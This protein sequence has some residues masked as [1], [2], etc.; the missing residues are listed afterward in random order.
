MTER[1]R[2]RAGSAPAAKHRAPRRGTRVPGFSL[3]TAGLVAAGLLVVVRPAAAP[4]PAYVDAAALSSVDLAA[5]NSRDVGQD[6]ALVVEKR[7]VAPET[8]TITDDTIAKGVSYVK[9]P[10]AAG[11]EE[12][13]YRVMLSRGKEVSRSVVSRVSVK[14]AVDTVIVQGSG[15]PAALGANLDSLA[16]GTTKPDGARRWAKVYIA[17]KY[18]WGQDQFVCLDKLWTRESNWRYKAKNKSSSAYGIPQAL[19]G[20]RMETYGKD[21]LTNPTV[22]MKWGANYIEKRYDTPC[23]AWAAFGRKGWY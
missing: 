8:V 22:Q 6:Y 20:K 2:H 3:G 19:P 4:A 23:G 21:W 10:G 17:Q 11:S 12:V 13:T 15:D 5:P 18:G 14:A 1:G 16:P 9:T 7:K